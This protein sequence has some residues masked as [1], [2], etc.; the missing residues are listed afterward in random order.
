MFEGARAALPPKRLGMYSAARLSI[1][2]LVA[3]VAMGFSAA[4][5]LGSFMNSSGRLP[6]CHLTHSAYSSGYAAL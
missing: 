1:S 6:S 4:V 5:S 2:P 3:R